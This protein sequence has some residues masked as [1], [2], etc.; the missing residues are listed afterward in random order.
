[1]AL[2]AVEAGM[3]YVADDYLAVTTDSHPRALNLFSTAKLDAGHLER[4]ADLAAAASR[5]PR[6][7][8]DE[9]FVLDV[10]QAWPG[11]LIAELPLRAV[12]LPRIT[13]AATAVRPAS[14]G[15]ALLAL[16]PST[17]MQMPYDRGTILAPLGALVRRLPC[18]SID[19]GDDREAWVGALDEI[20][21]RAMAPRPMVGRR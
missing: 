7:E 16:A 13:G 17:M 5:S 6:P 4:F 3:R 10:P 19:V 11:A 8:Q 14:A 15:Q 21:E 20:L 18:F 9:K 12:A 1:M 2:A